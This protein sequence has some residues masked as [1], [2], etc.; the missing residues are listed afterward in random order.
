MTGH[1]FERSKAS[2]QPAKSTSLRLG[3]PPAPPGPPH[4]RNRATGLASG[5]IGV[6]LSASP[7]KRLRLGKKCHA[8]VDRMP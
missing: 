5:R 4:P 3:N 8:D 2:S 6:I 1:N 7:K